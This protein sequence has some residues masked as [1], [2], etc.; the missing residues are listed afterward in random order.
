MIRT[1]GLQAVGNASAAHRAEEVHHP[2]GLLCEVLGVSRAGSGFTVPLQLL[3]WPC[4]ET[5]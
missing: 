5:R 2:I 4:Y 1:K 3:H